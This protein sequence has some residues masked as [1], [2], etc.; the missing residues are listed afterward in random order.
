MNKVFLGDVLEIA[1]DLEENSVDLIITSPPYFGLRTYKSNKKEEVGSEESMIE[2]VERLKKIFNGLKTL[3][4]DS[5]SIFLNIGDTYASSTLRAGQTAPDGFERAKRNLTCKA[6]SNKYPKGIRRDFG[7]VRNKSLMGV[8]WRVALAMIDD[9]WILRNDIIWAKRMLFD[10]GH[11]YGVH[12]PQPTV[13]DRFMDTKEYIFMFTKNDKYYFDKF[14]ADFP[15]V[16]SLKIQPGKTG[17]V[18]IFPEMLPALIILAACP[19]GGLVLDPFAGSGTTLLAAKA[20]GCQ[21]IGIDICEE[22]VELMESRLEQQEE[23]NVAI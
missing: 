18:A 8:P 11:F 21:Y 23:I 16:W 15:S 4:K 5:G 12:K 6:K 2:Y 20:L 17:H 3:L 14:Y 10:S 9:G 19:K 1:A 13:I 7:K 22:N